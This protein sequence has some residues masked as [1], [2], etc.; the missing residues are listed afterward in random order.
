MWSKDWHVPDS[1]YQE[2]KLPAFFAENPDAVRDIYH[3]AMCQ[4]TGA[5]FAAYYAGGTGL[6]QWPLWESAAR[7]HDLSAEI[8]QTG[9][10]LVGWASGADLK[11]LTAEEFEVGLF[12][13]FDKTVILPHADYRLVLDPRMAKGFVSAAGHPLRDAVSVQ[14]DV[15]DEIRRVAMRPRRRPPGSD[16]SQPLR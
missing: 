14:I 10:F 15:S 7:W 3:Q 6:D 12:P 5:E 11:K 8:G 13:P 9:T 2:E 1:V 16:A 4:A